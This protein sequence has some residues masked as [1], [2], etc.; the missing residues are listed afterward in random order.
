MKYV[1]KKMAAAVVA[2]GVALGVG[3]GAVAAHAE[4][5]HGVTVDRCYPPGAPV[6]SDGK[7]YDAETGRPMRQ[8]KL[9]KG[10]SP[11]ALKARAKAKEQ[12]LRTKVA[13]RQAAEA[14]RVAGRQP[15][16][17]KATGQGAAGVS[18]P[19]SAKQRRQA[20]VACAKLDSPEERTMCREQ[21]GVR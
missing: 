8:C 2:G 16:K 21:A 12:A 6:G 4:D 17:S 5:R 18:R 10:N 9:P 1:S 20:A 15:A 13:I 3:A 7:I 11:S 19:T 14:Q